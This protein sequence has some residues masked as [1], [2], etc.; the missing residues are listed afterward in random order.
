MTISG[1][2]PFWRSLPRRACA[3]LTLACYLATALNLPL[4][5]P[6]ATR[7]SGDE[8]YPCQDHA[9]G[10]QSAQ[11][12]WAGCCCLPPEQRWAWA[13]ERNIEP[14]AYAERPTSASWNTPRVRDQQETSAPCCTRS[15]AGTK[16]ERRPCC[17]QASTRPAQAEPRPCCQNHP[18]PP[19]KPDASTAPPKQADPKGGIRWGLVL[20]ALK[21]QGNGTL[22]VGSGAA[23][24][25]PPPLS[26]HPVPVNAGQLSWV[27]DTSD[28]VPTS[29]PSP[30]PRPAH[31]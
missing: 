6:A 4:P 8:P 9:C 10:C 30:P 13:R 7:K 16:P 24:P 5:I 3:G 27:D 11:Q 20:S 25:A 15:T 31:A 23:L 1:W 19:G 17:Q 12:C 21:C 28:P 2:K 29:P 22:W 18:A 14:P 26:W